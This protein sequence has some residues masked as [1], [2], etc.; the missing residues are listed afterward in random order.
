MSVNV[1]SFLV[2]YPEFSNAGTAMLTAQL[3]QC[4]L[5]VSDSFEGQRDQVVMLTLADRLASGPWGRDARLVTEE[6]RSTTYSIE[7]ER[8]KRAN[9]VRALR[10]GVSDSGSRWCR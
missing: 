8:L 2:A 10:L 7:L 5:I 1:A 4:E 6:G 9:A 3:A